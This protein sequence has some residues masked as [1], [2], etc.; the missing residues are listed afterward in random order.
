M[1]SMNG[2]VWCGVERRETASTDGRCRRMLQQ[3][4]RRRR[5][6]DT[7]THRLTDTN[8]N[9]NNMCVHL[10]LHKMNRVV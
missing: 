1:A 7:R 2:V 6:K 8:Y 10:Y 5:Q 9:T 3:Q 4:R